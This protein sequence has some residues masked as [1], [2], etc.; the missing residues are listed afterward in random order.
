MQQCAIYDISVR[1]R[2]GIIMIDRK[3]EKYR[4]G[5]TVTAG[6]RLHVT[7]AP[8]GRIFFNR[9]VHDL[10]SKPS[11]VYL[12]LSRSDDQ[13][14]VEPASARLPESLPVL[15]TKQ[16]WRVNAAPFCRHFRLQLETCEKF[17]YP[18][19]ANGHHLLKLSETV[20]VSNAMKGRKRK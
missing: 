10:L 17:I 7:L 6:E 15:E 3:F 20:T 14:A 19:I 9:R 11:A 4:G 1:R 18:E 8:N 5:P 13:I 12:Y 2:D 16:G